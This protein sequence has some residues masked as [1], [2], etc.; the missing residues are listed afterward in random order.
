[1]FEAAG[2]LHESPLWRGSL[3]I[4]SARSH[5]AESKPQRAA[6]SVQ[7]PVLGDE[8]FA[9]FKDPQ[10]SAFQPGMVAQAR[11]L[12]GRIGDERC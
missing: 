11:G 7:S 1:M 5:G 3:R 6:C 8:G 2:A 9:S 4:S 10:A 12:K